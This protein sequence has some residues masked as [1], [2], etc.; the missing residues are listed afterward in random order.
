MKVLY[1]PGRQQR[2]SIAMQALTRAYLA[3]GH[4]VVVRLGL[5]AFTLPPKYL[6]E[7]ATSE[8]VTLRTPEGML[9]IYKPRRKP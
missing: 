8:A 4:A 6:L 7:R 1:V 2:K 9:V 3:A 5:H